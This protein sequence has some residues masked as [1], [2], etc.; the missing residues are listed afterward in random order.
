MTPPVF[1]YSIFIATS[2]EF[3]WQAITDGTITSRYWFGRRIASTWQPKTPITFWDDAGHGLDVS[4]VILRCEPL[5][6]LSYTWQVE[7]DEQMRNEH[8]SRVTFAITPY[9]QMV[10][11][12]LTQDQFDEKYKTVPDAFTLCWPAI[13]SSLKSLLETDKPLALQELLSKVN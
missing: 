1:N 5:R 4:G 2:A 3:L 6:L 9:Q 13:L 11:L 10:R 8:P 7:Y 12:Q